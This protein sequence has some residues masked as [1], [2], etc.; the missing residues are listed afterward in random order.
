MSSHS[1]VSTGPDLWMRFDSRTQRLMH[2]AAALSTDGTLT[3]TDLKAALT[4]ECKALLNS[5][6]P[7]LRKRITSR[8]RSL[9][10]GQ[11]RQA[12]RRNDND[13]K[14]VL[15]IAGQIS[16]QA[17][18]PGDATLVNGPIAPATIIAAILIHEGTLG[19]G[20]VRSIAKA[21][22]LPSAA[23]NSLIDWPI[24][25]I[26]SEELEG[27][28]TDAPTMADVIL[29]KWSEAKALPVGANQEELLASI[30]RLRQHLM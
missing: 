2:S 15:V 29:R 13:V 10:Y 16:S 21:I 4:A 12:P 7:S 25:P 23:I 28:F 9:A 1:F 22:G 11:I 3:L 14:A 24:G 6:S 5:I 8:P 27:L 20:N 17:V 19:L 18:A 30:E 26:S